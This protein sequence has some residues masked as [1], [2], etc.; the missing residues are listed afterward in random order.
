MIIIKNR[1]QKNLESFSF[2]KNL[3]CVETCDLLQLNK[4][5]SKYVRENKTISH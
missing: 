3:T 4:A 5:Y 2:V 1:D